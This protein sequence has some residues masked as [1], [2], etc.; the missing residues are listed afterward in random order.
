MKFNMIKWLLGGGYEY[1]RLKNHSIQ[2]I[3]YFHD[4]P[5]K[6]KV[7]DPYRLTVLK[8]VTK[9]LGYMAPDNIKKPLMLTYV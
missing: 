3:H 4:F 6:P 2:S 9:T 1:R 7:T 8:W 5:N